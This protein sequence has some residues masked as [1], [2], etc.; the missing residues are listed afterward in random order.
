M[1][2]GYAEKLSFR[3]DLGGQLGSEELSESSDH[4]EQKI[5]QLVE[6]VTDS[7]VHKSF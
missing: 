4:L 5:D 7:H 1:S 2:L 3:D 6:L